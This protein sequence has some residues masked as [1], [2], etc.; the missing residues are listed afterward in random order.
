MR[1][2]T[3]LLGLPTA[4]LRPRYGAIAAERR[5]AMPRIP[6]LDDIAPLLI[7]VIGVDGGSIPGCYEIIDGRFI[8][9]VEASGRRVVEVILDVPLSTSGM[10]AR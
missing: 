2:I 8:V 6:R 5:Q 4:L 1:S 3:W 9:L 10:W 7:R